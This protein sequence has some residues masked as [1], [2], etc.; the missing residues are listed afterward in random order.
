VVE[1]DSKGVVAYSYAGDVC[2]DVVQDGHHM[3]ALKPMLACSIFLGWVVLDVFSSLTLRNAAFDAR[4][5]RIS[6]E[7]GQNFCLPLEPLI[8][9]VVVHESLKSRISTNGFPRASFNVVDIVVVEEAEVR[10][11]IPA[12]TFRRSDKLL[13]G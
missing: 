8:V 10:W 12:C 3:T 6:R 13:V 11:G 9:S 5:E 2:A 4:I 7:E 1:E